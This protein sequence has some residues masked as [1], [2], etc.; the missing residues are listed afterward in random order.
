[1]DS[2]QPTVF[3]VDDDP[4]ARESVAALTESMGV[5]T[6]S[7]ASAEDF[8][9][10]FDSARPGCLVTDVRLGGMNGLELQEE[11]VRQEVTVPVV[12]ITGYADVPLAVRAMQR[13]AVTLLEKP[14]QHRELWDGIRAALAMDAEGREEAAQR[15]EIRDRVES[16][17]AKEHDVMQRIIGGDLNKTIAADLQVS[18][19]TVE[20]RRHNVLKKMQVGSVAELVRVVM[21]MTSGV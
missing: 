18:T 10:V 4:V 21:K 5:H 15:T 8:L 7:F 11:L 14:C 6:E 13:G 12:V 17:T 19:R 2:T 20:L 3:V 16:L 9:E 1:M